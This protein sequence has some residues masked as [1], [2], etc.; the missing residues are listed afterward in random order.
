MEPETPPLGLAWPGEPRYPRTY[1][2]TLRCGPGQDLKLPT[3][4][5]RFPSLPSPA[6][7]LEEQ[8]V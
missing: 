3:S 8:R 2:H 6:D 4:L 1:R 7:L 5:I